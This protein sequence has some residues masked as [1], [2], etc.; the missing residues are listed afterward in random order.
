ML[1]K[2]VVAAL[3]EQIN[4]ELYS[5]YL[6]LSMAAYCDSI[7]LKGFANW[8][9]VQVQEENFHAMKF[10]DYVLSRQGKVVLKPIE[11]PPTTWKSPREVFEAV[12]AHEEKVTALINALAKVARE[13]E[14]NATSILLQWYITEQVE[15]EANADAVIQKLKLI[16]DN[17][18]GLFMVDQELAARVFVPPAAGAAAP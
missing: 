11:G 8:M 10:F 1:N 14:D 12:Y 4:A 15:E 16:G 2:K 6:Y 13:E 5:S 9:R 17:P 3:N 18:A 7:N